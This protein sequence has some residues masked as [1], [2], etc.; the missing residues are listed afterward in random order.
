MQ[1]EEQGARN[2]REASHLA[3]YARP[4]LSRI[5]SHRM[6]AGPCDPVARYAH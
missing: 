5:A 4:P 1:Q 3:A 2:T 6:Q